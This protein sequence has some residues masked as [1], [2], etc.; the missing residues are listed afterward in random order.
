MA[1]LSLGGCSADAREERTYVT[2]P[3]A[4]LMAQET[5]PSVGRPTYQ[6]PRGPY[7]DN[8]IATAGR[9]PF[10][11]TRAVYSGYGRGYYR[12]GGGSWATDSQLPTSPRL[13]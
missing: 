6:D 9:F 3:G 2:R 11:W 1:S 4:E 13:R 7:L 5:P 8:P 10:Y 12:R